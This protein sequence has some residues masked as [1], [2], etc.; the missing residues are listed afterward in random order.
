M[1][2]IRVNAD[3]AESPKL[4][5]SKRVDWTTR[6][7][8]DCSTRWTNLI[9]ASWS[10]K[11]RGGRAICVKNCFAKASETHLNWCYAQR[12]FRLKIY[13]LS[14]NVILI[15]GCLRFWRSALLTLIPSL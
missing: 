6:S 15:V 2:A 10:L 7:W 12:H 1:N 11:S 3:F 4:L 5:L 14:G 8:H 13:S 9:P